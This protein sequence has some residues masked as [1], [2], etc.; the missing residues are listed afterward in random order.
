[1]ERDSQSMDVSATFEENRVGEQSR[2]QPAIQTHKDLDAAVLRAQEHLLSL[3][4]P[5]GF[6]V[7]E[8]MVDSTL[9]SDTIAFHH[10]NGKVDPEWQRKAVN[11]IFSMQLP[12]GGW[13]I[14]YGGPSE[15][16]ATIK[17]YLALKLA[18]VPVTDW[19]MLRPRA[20]AINL[21]AP[22]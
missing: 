17:A 16:N 13:N 5:D 3:Q 9:V 11:H 4:K 1:M 15:V 12:D 14:Y 8:L 10:W 22:P 20:V 18:G 7:G 2:R 21:L 19:R 6:W